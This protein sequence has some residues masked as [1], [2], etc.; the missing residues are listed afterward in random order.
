MELDDL[1]REA[2]D[3][4]AAR[5][6]PADFV[7]VV[8]RAR[9]RRRRL[10][11]MGAAGLVA[12]VAV[13]VAAV[14]GLRSAP[15]PVPP[16]AATPLDEAEKDPELAPLI[17]DVP[18]IVWTPVDGKSIGAVKTTEA[19]FV[20]GQPFGVNCGCAG[21]G[22]DVNLRSVFPDAPVDGAAVVYTHPVTMKQIQRSVDLLEAVPGV[23]SARL[24]ILR[25]LW[26][27]ASVTVV[28]E[29]H[30]RQQDNRSIPADF[31]GLTFQGPSTVKG[32]SKHRYTTWVYYAGSGLDRAGLLKIKSV[33]ATPWGVS[34]E[35]A[36]IEPIK[37]TQG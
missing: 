3:S 29:T 18:V 23:K 28:S 14:A 13:G 11:A 15:P 6:K 26:F 35:K 33:L 7:T 4:G 21:G 5:T 19:F 12:C 25:G 27:A 20:H 22:E 10:V 2:A 34:P 24:L 9:G 16:A 32:S 36:V 30:V 31:V 17:T 8:R 1:L 37:I